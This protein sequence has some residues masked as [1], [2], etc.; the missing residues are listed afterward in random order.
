MKAVDIPVTTAV[1]ALRAAGVAFTPHLYDYVD[2]GGTTHAA[3]SLG[4]PEHSVIKTLVFEDDSRKKPLIVLMHGDREVSTKQLARVLGVK[5][6]APASP[7]AVEKYTGYVPGGVSP[8][9]TR[10]TMPIY[11]EESILDLGDI[12]INGGKRGFLVH[13]SAADAARVLSA[14]P[15][16]VAIVVS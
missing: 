1:R 2:H 14:V 15:V 4:V 5:S 8:F 6:I 12:Y 10:S 9:G 7:A 3:Q 16:A 13:V 11:I